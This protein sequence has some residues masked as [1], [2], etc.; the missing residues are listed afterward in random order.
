[1]EDNQQQLVIAAPTDPSPPTGTAVSAI[2]PAAHHA[3]TTMPISTPI[4]DL[5]ALIEAIPA[6]V[7]IENVQFTV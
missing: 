7:H 6:P 2:Q 5:A 4:V 3:P 1:M